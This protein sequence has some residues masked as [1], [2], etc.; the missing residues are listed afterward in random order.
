MVVDWSS[1]NVSSGD[2]KV[3]QGIIGV[4]WSVLCW[5]C[6]YCELGQC[7]FSFQNSGMTCCR[8]YGKKPGQHV[9]GI[10][11]SSQ[12]IATAWIGTVVASLRRF[13]WGAKKIR[14]VGS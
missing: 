10:Q 9:I 12:H 5:N 4:L 11:C 6:R 8:G 7:V 3:S 1:K 14:Y 2:D 13:C